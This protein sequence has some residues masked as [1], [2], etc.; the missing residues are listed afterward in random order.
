MEFNTKQILHDLKHLL[1][2]DTS[3]KLRKVKEILDAELLCGD[4]FLDREIKTAYGA[5]LLSDV[6]AFAN[7]DALLL[8]GLVNTQVVRT[9]ELADISSI[10]FVRGKRPDKSIIT[11]SEKKNI[12]LLTTQYLMY[13]ACGKLYME[14]LARASKVLKER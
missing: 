8:T 11:L 5:D 7:A 14:G 1:E 6:L 13:E 3:M 4:E 10:C 9:A 12:P 2:T